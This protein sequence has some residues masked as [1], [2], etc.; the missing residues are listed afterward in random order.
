MDQLFDK[1]SDRSGSV[2]WLK[3]HFTPE[4]VRDE[5]MVGYAGAEFEFATCPAFCRGV[6]KLVKKGVFGF[7]LAQD[8]YRDAVK[9]WMKHVRNYEIE[10]SW[11]VPTHGTI[12]S[13]AT[14]IRLF[15]D[16]GDNIV[17]LSPNYNRYNQAARR[18]DRGTVTVAWK[19]ET[20][21]YAVP[22]EELE[23]AFAVPANKIFV[24]CNP[25]NPTGH[26]YRKEELER[27][28]DLAMKY[29]MVVFS[30]EIFAEV[31][32]EGY[33]V[34]PYTKVAGPR[35]LA[36]SCT[37]M[38]KVFSLTGVNHANVLIEN[39]TLR[40]YYIK[41][42]DAD[43][44]G[45]VDPMVYAGMVEAY[46][47]EGSRWVAD[48]REYIW[49]NFLLLEQFMKEEL[50]KAKIIRPQGTYVVWV[51][52]RAYEEQWTEMERLLCEDGLFVGDEGTEYFGRPTCV[53]YSIAVPR[54]ELRKTL[55]RVKNALK[56]FQGRDQEA[57]G[58]ETL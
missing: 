27:L 49:E 51:D 34:I 1:K 2:R 53:R 40:K 50:P 39:D 25:N 26:I 11:I 18:L 17:V 24:L 55:L 38:G 14:T 15:T 37:S 5:G 8:E 6:E 48:L 22:W 23:K 31:V 20:D 58:Y 9:W 54:A 36:I 21:G 3:D 19:E 43:H 16:P 46:G 28:A 12:F 13:L 33:E 32:F 7:T 42:R 41:Q 56:T 10:D 52:Y 45:S 4:A 35:A 57:G 47:E 44:F 29:G 30:D